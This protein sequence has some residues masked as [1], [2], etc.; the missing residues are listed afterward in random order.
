M[1]PR[2]QNG[3]TQ[4]EVLAALSN[5]GADPA[6]DEVARIHAS[7][8]S[9]SLRT[10]I[11]RETAVRELI[12]M[13]KE[14]PQVSVS[15][16]LATV[17]SDAVDLL[18]RSIVPAERLEAIASRYADHDAPRSID[19]RKAVSRHA[20]DLL[21][22]MVPRMGPKVIGQAD[23]YLREAVHD[24][25]IL[26]DPARAE[27]SVLE[28]LAGRYCE[29]DA[30]RSHEIRRAALDNARELLQGYDTADRFA[31]RPL[32]RPE[33]FFGA[34]TA[35]DKV[36]TEQLYA[37]LGL[38][39]VEGKPLF[40]S[41]RGSRL[42]FQGWMSDSEHYNFMIDI[43][44]RHVDLELTARGADYTTRLAIPGELLGFERE[45]GKDA[46]FSGYAGR[47]FSLQKGERSANLYDLVP[48]LATFLNR[49]L[50]LARERVPKFAEVHR[51]DS[52]MTASPESTV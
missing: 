11:D 24:L 43:A 27:D 19:M 47:F 8:S 9:R 41:Y 4:E 36:R 48:A 32:F 46:Q 1:T 16:A 21:A 14:R 51:A 28:D 38:R 29:H 22:G 42:H 17:L 2:S 50:A 26:V 18:D 6:A 40:D 35:A 7:I 45:T 15:I 23:R 3:I 25:S 33:T 37:A 5:D 44:E 30:P 52:G 12:A 10:D 34:Y 20:A 39:A 31:R 49:S 13:A